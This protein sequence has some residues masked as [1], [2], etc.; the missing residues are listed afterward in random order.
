VAAEP[1]QPGG[2]GISPFDLPTAPPPRERIWDLCLAIAAGGALGGALRYELNSVL[3]HEPDALPWSTFIENVLGSFLL[4][5][6]MVFLLEWWPPNRYLRP[7]LGVGVLGGF[8]TFSAYTSEARTLLLEGE[9]ALALFYLLGTPAL[10]LAAAAAGTIL[11]TAL[12]RSRT[13]SS[14]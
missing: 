12:I 9:G 3:L 1:R 4:A 10:G 8:T 6:V 7:F 11:A 2:G 5:L 13:R 14:G